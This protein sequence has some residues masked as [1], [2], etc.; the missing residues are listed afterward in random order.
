M[1]AIGGLQERPHYTKKSK[2]GVQTYKTTQKHHLHPSNYSTSTADPKISE[3]RG[4]T[5]RAFGMP[6]L[7]L[8]ATFPANKTPKRTIVDRVRS[9][10]VNPS[11]SIELNS[12]L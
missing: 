10:P 4:L 1:K 3:K 7:G 12:D 2:N 9:I 11:T 5:T 8:V 6:L